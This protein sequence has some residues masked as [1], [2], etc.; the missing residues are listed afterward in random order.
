MGE[1]ERGRRDGRK[2]VWERCVSSVGN[3]S[4]TVV[5]AVTLP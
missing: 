1:G 5:T 2:Y 3:L 4:F